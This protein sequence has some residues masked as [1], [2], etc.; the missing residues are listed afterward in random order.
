MTAAAPDG[1]AR[2]FEEGR[3]FTPDGRARLVAITP[4]PPATPTDQDYPLILNTGR[5]RDQWHSMTRTGK[6][7]RLTAHA[8]EPLVQV[9]PRDA[10]CHGVSNG[11]LARLDS[12]QGELLARVAVTPDQRPG[13]VFVP[14]HW[15]DQFASRGRV[16]AL[17]R[18]VT[19]PLSG[20]PEFKHAPVRLRPYRPRWYGFLLAHEPLVFQQRPDYW[21]VARAEGCWRY[22]LAGATMPE[23]WNAWLR[24]LSGDTGGEW[25]E[26][27]DPARGCYR[28]ACLVDGRLRAVLFVADST[29]LP[30]R[31]SLQAL[32]GAPLSAAARRSL[33]S[34]RPPPGQLDTGPTVCACF[35]IGR[36]TLIDGIRRQGL[37][38]VEAV[39]EVLG[40]G[41]NCGSC[42]PEI[43]VLLESSG[44]ILAA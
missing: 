31:E 7:A 25:L 1:T 19:D 39:G 18:A 13:S 9:H 44:K 17:V 35:G 42:R 5:L 41:S 10:A 12:P 26:F 30:A 38:S 11:D 22:E 40:A 15:S 32:F 2:L 34:G 4:R 36:T 28:A 20:Q 24:A 8:A 3:F 23:G 16:D 29:A 6:T 37:E 33:L 27:A 14:I 21:V 43:R